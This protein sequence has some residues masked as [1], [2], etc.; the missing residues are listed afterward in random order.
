MS[1]IEHASCSRTREHEIVVLS[2]LASE[3]ARFYSDQRG[4]Q[5]CRPDSPDFQ[6]PLRGVRDLAS[7][8]R[9]WDRMRRHLA[10]TRPAAACRVR[11]SRAG[12]R[13]CRRIRED[14]DTHGEH[15]CVGGVPWIDPTSPA[16]PASIPPDSPP[17]IRPLR[18][19]PQ[20]WRWACHWIDS[21]RARSSAI[22][23]ASM[24]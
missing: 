15:P 16:K 3:F 22:A 5:L 24:Y 6:D 7:E 18:A 4:R 14:H 1:R 17:S 12:V 9:A 21:H 11:G 2:A 20:R 13:A 19:T 10:S 23:T 8:F